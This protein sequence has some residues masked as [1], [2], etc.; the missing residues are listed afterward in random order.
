MKDTTK[1]QYS[2][3]FIVRD[4][5]CDLQGI[6]NNAVYQHYLE[7]ARHEFLFSRNIDFARLHNEKKD[8][9]VTR[10]EIDYKHSLVSR[11][12]FQVRLY[13]RKEGNLRV[14]FFQDIYRMPDEKIIIK[15]RIEG[16]CLNHGRL[17]K[18]EDIPEF[19][20]LFML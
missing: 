6:V 4:Y 10:V 14:I 19:R 16:V 11:D 7:H 1:Y 2:L 8:M 13:T 15:S 3:D 9:V 18:P 17:V 5:E 12:Q 20:D